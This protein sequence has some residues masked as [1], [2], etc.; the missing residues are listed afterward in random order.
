[1]DKELACN[2][3]DA[4][5][6]LVRFLGWE[7]PLEEGTTHSSILVRK[8]SDTT[9]ATEYKEVVRIHSF[10]KYSLNTYYVPDAV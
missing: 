7:D 8:E 6:I 9:E 1:M 3:G 5:E 4:G 2:A 10:K